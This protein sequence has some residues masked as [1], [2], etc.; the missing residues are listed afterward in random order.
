[1]EQDYTELGLVY[2]RVVYCTTCT[3]YPVPTLLKP[4]ILLFLSH[5]NLFNLSTKLNLS[6]N[7]LSNNRQI[8]GQR[9]KF[10]F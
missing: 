9:D 1:M 7:N 2:C 10:N 4:G 3:L 6:N 5:L 8:R